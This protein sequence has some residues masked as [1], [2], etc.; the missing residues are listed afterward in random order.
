MANLQFADDMLFAKLLE[1]VKAFE[2]VLGLRV[3]V[4]KSVIAWINLNLLELKNLP[5]LWDV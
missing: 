5:L 1:I 2:A 4:N 3:N